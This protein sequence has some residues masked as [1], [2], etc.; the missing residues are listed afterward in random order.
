MSQV[1]NKTIATQALVL[2]KS[3][4][5]HKDNADRTNPI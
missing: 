3:T 4:S 1:A 5:P 2:N